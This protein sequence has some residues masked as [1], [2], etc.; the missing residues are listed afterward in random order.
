MDPPGVRLENL[1]YPD[2]LRD[3]LEGLRGEVLTPEVVLHILLDG[4]IEL[5]YLTERYHTTAGPKNLFLVVLLQESLEVDYSDLQQRCDRNEDLF[6]KLSEEAQNM[7]LE[8]RNHMSASY[9]DFPY[10]A[11]E[12]SMR[13]AISTGVLE[14]FE[15]QQSTLREVLREKGKW[16]LPGPDNR[17]GYAKIIS[18]AA[19]E[20][21]K[22]GRVPCAPSKCT[23]VACVGKPP[24]ESGV[25]EAPPSQHPSGVTGWD[26]AMGPE[27]PHGAVSDTPGQSWAVCSQREADNPYPPTVR[28]VWDHVPLATFLLGIGQERKEEVYGL[29]N[30]LIK[31][32]GRLGY[33]VLWG[34]GGWKILPPET[35]T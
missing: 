7:V 13:R 1:L 6:G 23:A 24:C 20:I 34:E 8:A 25:G 11:Q 15:K 17:P 9:R 22:L 2:D 26:S 16:K 14:E 27:G 4:G 33:H 5:D 35:G 12:W 28:Q 18:A 29:A 21:E 3:I 31:D 19:A 30:I 32:N 10:S